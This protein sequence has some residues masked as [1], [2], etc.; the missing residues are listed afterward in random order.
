MVQSFHKTNIFS[1]KQSF[2]MEDHEYSC[3]I[4]KNQVYSSLVKVF[5]LTG[6]NPKDE[7]VAKQRHLWDFLFTVT[8]EE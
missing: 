5:S 2:M 6:K 7:S 4:M 3:R 1:K 8:K